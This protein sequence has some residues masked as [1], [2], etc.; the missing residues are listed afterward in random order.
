MGSTDSGPAGAARRADRPAAP[1]P[2]VCGAHRGGA[3][4]DAGSD[5]AADGGSD[6]AAR[7]SGLARWDGGAAGL[8][9]IAGQPRLLKQRVRAEPWAW[10]APGLAHEL[11][12]DELVID[13]AAVPAGGE[14]VC[15][16]LPQRA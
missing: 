4:G 8:R 16:L 10:R 7:R 3:A 12:I 11:W 1:P 5:R 13:A 14:G 6:T 15:R 2:D 9:S